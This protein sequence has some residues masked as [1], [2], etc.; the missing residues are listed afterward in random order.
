MKNSE[1]GLHKIEDICK[2]LRISAI[3]LFTYFDK[4][5]LYKFKLENFEELLESLEL[6]LSTGEVRSI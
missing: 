3:D 5:H 2:T 6:R 4:K 1:L